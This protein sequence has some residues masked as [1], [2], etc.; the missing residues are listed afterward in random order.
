MSELKKIEEAEK[1]RNLSPQNLHIRLR[2]VE[3]VVFVSLVLSL[4]Q[5]YVSIQNSKK[6]NVQIDGARQEADARVGEP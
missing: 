4:V 2:V 3:A 6:I 5:G 1:G